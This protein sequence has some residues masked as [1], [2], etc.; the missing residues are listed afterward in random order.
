MRSSSLR[1]ASV[2]L[3][4]LLTLAPAAP[5]GA[6]AVML[7]RSVENVLQAPLDFVLTPVTM[8]VS[9]VRGAILKGEA[10][11]L[12]KAA[13]TPIMAIPYLPTCTL[14]SIFGPA[15]RGLEGAITFPLA[16]ALAGTDVDYHLFEPSG[17]AL[18][19]KKTTPFHF[20]FGTNYCEGYF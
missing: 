8:G 13:T 11:P 5:A 4:G 17:A 10:S 19:D 9:F 16:L 15:E 18:V 1:L 6:A 20:F 14:I 7:K 2:A 12:A 3:V